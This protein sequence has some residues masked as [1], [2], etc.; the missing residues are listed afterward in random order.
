MRTIVYVPQIIP[1]SLVN[2]MNGLSKLKMLELIK[3][4]SL[5]EM[6]KKSISIHLPLMEFISLRILPSKQINSILLKL[7]LKLPITKL[8][9]NQNVIILTLP[10][11][12]NM[13]GVE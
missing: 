7:K 5:L 12:A 8:L 2:L 10:I 1:P 13:F 4:K 3:L 9:L 11:I 6:L